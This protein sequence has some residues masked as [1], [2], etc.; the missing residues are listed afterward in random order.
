MKI[1]FWN[2]AL[3][4]LTGFVASSC[5]KSVQ[6]GSPIYRHEDSPNMTAPSCSSQQWRFTQPSDKFD[7]AVDLLF[8]VDT[9]NS[10]ADKRARLASTIPAFL[11]Q[12]PTDSDLRIGVMLGHGG[13]SKYSGRLFAASGLPLVLSSKTLSIQAMQQKLQSTLSLAPRDADEANGEALLYSLNRSFDPMY[14]APIRTQGFYRDNSTLAVV[15]ITD[16]NDVCYSPQLHGF[17]AFPDFSPSVGNWEAVAFS[18]YCAGISPESMLDRAKDFKPD[19]RI[20]WAGITHVDPAKVPR[21]SEEAIGHGINELVQSAPDGMLIEITSSS[22]SDG[23]AKLGSAVRIQQNLDVSFYLD[24]D[25]PIDPKTIRAEVDGKIV[26]AQ[27]DPVR[28]IVDLRPASAGSSG[29]SIEIMACSS[30]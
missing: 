21:G 10:L 30:Q 29:S 13:A 1:D 25:I 23:L 27:F 18:R 17:T 3:A 24:G 19:H 16:E 15:F 26:Y 5:G 9:S 22:Y 7:R 4:L 11:T 28:R 6:I 20:S 8:V 14:S 12:L 2:L